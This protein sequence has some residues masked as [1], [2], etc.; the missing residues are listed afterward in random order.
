MKLVHH[1]GEISFQYDLD[2]RTA[3]V[4]VDVRRNCTKQ[5]Q[6]QRVVGADGV[7]NNILTCDLP[8]LKT[9]PKSIDD[10]AFI[11]YTRLLPIIKAKYDDLR[12]RSGNNT[13][14]WNLTPRRA[15]MTT[16]QVKCT[17]KVT[18][19]AVTTRVTMN[20]WDLIRQ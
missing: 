10:Q 19:T 9:K 15:T 8:R 3:W 20:E 17:R 5:H 14:I 11:L 16:V 13:S 7:T 1:S 18:L 12:R 2:E 4:K 6:N